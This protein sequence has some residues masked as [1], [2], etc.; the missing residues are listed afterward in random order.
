MAEMHFDWKVVESEQDTFFGLAQRES[1]YVSC[2]VSFPHL[3]LI[4][5]PIQVRLRNERN[6]QK[7]KLYE[8]FSIELEIRNNTSQLIDA[9][10]NLIAEHTE[11][12]VA[13]EV[14]SSMQLM[15]AISSSDC[16]VLRYTLFPQKLG[17]LML[18][19]LRVGDRNTAKVNTVWLVKDFTR[20]CYVTTN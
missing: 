16:Y 8:P 14:V 11:F 7:I 20:K 12:L 15:P 4:S 3:Y 19:K 10:C 18:P 5:V 13:G 2:V 1:R 9:Q 6:I 17:R